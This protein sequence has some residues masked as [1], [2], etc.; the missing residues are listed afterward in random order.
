MAG[1]S[2][3]GLDLRAEGARIGRS[4]QRGQGLGRFLKIY[5]LSVIVDHQLAVCP[6]Q[7]I[8]L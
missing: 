1:S 5:G 6:F 4:P 7:D 8:H 3:M 2:G